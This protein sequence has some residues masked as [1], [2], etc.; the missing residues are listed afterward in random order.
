M[1]SYERY[2]QPS[3]DCERVRALL[4]RQAAETGSRPVPDEALELANRELHPMRRS[5]RP[6]Q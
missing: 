1:L 6:R 5:R 3:G 4:K 2:L